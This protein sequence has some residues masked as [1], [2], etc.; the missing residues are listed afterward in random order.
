MSADKDME[1]VILLAQLA[2]LVDDEG[3]VAFLRRTDYETQFKH[4]LE[5]RCDIKIAMTCE[6]TIRFFAEVVT[7]IIG[8]DQIVRVFL[9][10]RRVPRRRPLW[11]LE[12]NAKRAVLEVLTAIRPYILTKDA[13]VDLALDYLRRASPVTRYRATDRDRRLATL[14][15]ALRNGC[16]EARAE[17]LALLGQVIPYQAATGSA[18]AEGV[19]EGL[20]TTGPSPNGNDPHE[21]PAPHLGIAGRVK[22]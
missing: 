14:A 13:E 12:V 21:R 7:G 16:G 6:R 11:R 17:A 18:Q 1:K 4:R 2:R 22:I 10:K 20:T 8:D 15:T 5:V 19:A 3:C 9:E